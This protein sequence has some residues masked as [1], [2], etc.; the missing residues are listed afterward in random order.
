MIRRRRQSA[1]CKAFAPGALALL[2]I[3]APAAGQSQ[4]SAAPGEDPV[5]AQP[6]PFSSLRL[7]DLQ[8]TRERPLFAQNRRKPAPPPV[9]A[10]APPVSAPKEE[11][12]D[13]RPHLSLRG[14]IRQESAT[15]IVLEDESASETVVVRSGGSYGRWRVTATSDDTVKLADGSEEL[16]LELFAR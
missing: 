5:P 4:P 16:H 3:A 12:P 2:L 14:I 7:E 6:R 1:A 15:L 10:V 9:L 13:T 11:P 8:A